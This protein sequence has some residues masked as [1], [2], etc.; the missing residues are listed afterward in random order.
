LFAEAAV[1]LSNSVRAN[2][3]MLLQFQVTAWRMPCAPGCSQHMCSC[4]GLQGFK[5]AVGLVGAASKEQERQQ[6]QR[7]QNGK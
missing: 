4:Y 1:Q 7:K 6:K 3:C 5:A 2:A